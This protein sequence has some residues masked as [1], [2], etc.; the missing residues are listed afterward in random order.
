MAILHRTWTCFTGL[1]AAL[2]LAHPSQAQIVTGEATAADGDS[3]VVA[4]RRVRLFGI[5]APELAQSCT[6]QG[7]AWN[8]GEQARD[9]LAELI[10]GNTV[11]CVGQGVDQHARL[12]AVCS[13]GGVE[14]NETMVA[15]GWALAYREFSDAYLPAETRA[16]SNGLGIW[17]SQFQRPSDYRLSQLPPPITA[18]VQNVQPV[19]RRAAAPSLSGCVIKGNR[20]RRGQWIYH[21]PGMP[22]YDQTRAEEMFCTEAEAQAAGYRRAIVRN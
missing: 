5:D 1:I 7:I 20:N 8:C 18:P 15:Y 22:Y 21:L 17:S 14:L 13:A 10:K 2:S 12:V 19:P 6:K 16:K 11:Y 4:G 3:L 9:N